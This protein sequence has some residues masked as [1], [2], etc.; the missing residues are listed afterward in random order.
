MQKVAFKGIQSLE[1]SR[2]KDKDDPH[3]QQLSK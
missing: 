2:E 3:S 1:N